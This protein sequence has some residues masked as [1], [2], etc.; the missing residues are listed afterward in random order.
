MQQ[1]EGQ[2]LAHKAIHC[3]K[4]AYLKN[5]YFIMQN[6][7]IHLCMFAGMELE[8]QRAERGRQR[9]IAPKEGIEIRAN[10][11]AYWAEPDSG[12]SKHIQCNPG[13]HGT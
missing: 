2:K 11:R 6:K 7:L 5:T 12:A 9:E 3:G 8:T 1:E 13:H 10:K 4:P